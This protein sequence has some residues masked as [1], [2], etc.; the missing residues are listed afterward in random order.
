MMAGGFAGNILHAD[1]S[2]QRSWIRPL[3]ESTARDFLGGLGICVKLARDLMPQRIHPLAPESVFVLGAGPLV[4]TDLPSS[5]RVYAIAKMPA[6]G[7]VGW[8]GAGGYR[9]GAQLKYAGYDHIVI[10]GKSEK[11]VYLYIDNDHI[12]LRSAGSLWGLGIEDTCHSIHRAFDAQTGVLAI[13]PAGEHQSAIAMAFVDR[14]STLGRGGFGAVMGSKN[15]KAIVVRGSGGVSAADPK[16]FNRL[17]GTLFNKIRNYPYLREWQDLGMLKA[18]PMVPKDVYDQIKIRRAACVSC[19]IGCKDIVRIPD[20]PFEGLTKHTSS[21]INLFTPMMFG[22]KN[23]WDAVKLVADLD[24]FGMDM[25]EF[26]G[27][28]AMTRDLASEGV[29]NLDADEP[30]IDL[31]SIK[32]MMS[33]AER[34]A[35]RMGTGDI[36]AD[37][38]IAALKK[39]G[40]EAEKRAPALIKGMQPYAGPG[41][42][43]PWDRFGTM[44]LGQALDPR[45]PHVGSGGSPT[46]FALRPLDTF[47]R[48]LTR[49]GIPD[50]AVERILGPGRNELHVG[51]LLRYSH[52]WFAMLGSLGVCARGQVNRFYHAGL[53]AEAY[54]AATGIPTTASEL[55]ERADRVWTTLRSINIREGMDDATATFPDQWFGETGFRDY[56]T[57]KPLTRDEVEGMK[58]EYIEE[59]KCLSPKTK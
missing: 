48:H 29:I 51:R 33:W 17:S 14:I 57:G 46:Y 36:L 6:S 13:G 9:F 32:S 35:M 56:L 38:F 55:R 49:M 20:G 40:P 22:M 37:G 2:A 19:P 30:E 26:F 34:M 5:S 25:F 45:G 3:D 54:E 47:P 52:A 10:S 42:A 53:C 39:F 27:L 59:W 16:R 7:A 18:F 50:D 28:L 4:G 31:A 8:C 21:A 44:E 15:L 58:R 24:D 11:P 41:A 1:L 23:P 12:E 43:L